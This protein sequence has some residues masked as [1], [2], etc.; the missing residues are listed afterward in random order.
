MGKKEGQYRDVVQEFFVE[1]FVNLGLDNN[2]IENFLKKTKTQEQSKTG[3][4][5]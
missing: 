4:M 1:Y 5:R 3:N 2:N